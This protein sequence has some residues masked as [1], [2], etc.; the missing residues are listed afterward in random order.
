MKMSLEGLTN[1]SEHD[2]E[3]FLEAFSHGTGVGGELT[4]LER[5]PGLLM[6]KFGEG[7]GDIFGDEVRGLDGDCE[8][9][10]RSG[11]DVFFGS[12]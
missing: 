2:D 9:L 8:D 7:D 12:P 3:M 11:G 4:V 5:E 6:Q 1:I 10:F